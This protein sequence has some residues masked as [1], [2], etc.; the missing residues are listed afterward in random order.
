MEDTLTL[1]LSNYS[2]V[3]EAHYYPPLELKPDRNYVFGLVELLTFNSIPHIYT[4]NNKQ[5]VDKQILEITVG[6]YEIDNLEKYLKDKLFESKIK[7]D[8]KPNNNTL[9]SSIKCLHSIDFQPDDS[10]GSLLGFTKRLL[11][12]SY[13]YDSD[14]P[15]QILKVNSV[16]VECNIT[17]GAYI[18]GKKSHTI[19]EFFPAVPPGYKIIEV[20]S[21]VIY[22]PVAVRRIG[23]LTLSL[24]D[25]S[26]NLF[27]FRGEDIS[28]RLHIKSVQWV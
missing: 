9:C 3:L 26:D 13:T 20:P 14:Q 12:P 8:L 1:S 7:I 23:N 15:V 25:Q 22:L 24:V 5:Y 4:Y 27:N 28:V 6:N 21:Q 19:H 16:R 17:T 11:N 2:S 18:N 10:I